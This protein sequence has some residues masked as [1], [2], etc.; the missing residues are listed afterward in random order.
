MVEA[1]CAVLAN[2]ANLNSSQQLIG[3][4]GGVT[5]LIKHLGKESSDSTRAAAVHCLACLLIESPANCR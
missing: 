4:E 2:M 3:I 5:E 1:A